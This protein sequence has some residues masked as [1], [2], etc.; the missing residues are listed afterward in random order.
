MLFV[1]HHF[2]PIKFY[3]F[4]NV[5]NRFNE[6]GSCKQTVGNKYFSIRKRLRKTRNYRETE[7]EN[8]ISL[9]EKQKQGATESVEIAKLEKLINTTNSLITN[10]T[11]YKSGFTTQTF[12]PVYSPA[13]A[14]VVS[15]FGVQ[16]YML[17]AELLL[18]A[19]EDS[20]VYNSTYYP[21]FGWRVNSSPV[22][23]QIRIN[24]EIDGSDLY[25]NSGTVENC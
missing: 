8:L 19:E 1:N 7:L 17:S 14:A 23:Q 18:H 10:Y 16:D 12:H 2:I 22:T 25:P 5:R 24:P 15:W 21:Q 13:I 4:C 3:G 6:S 11:N 20:T 9:F